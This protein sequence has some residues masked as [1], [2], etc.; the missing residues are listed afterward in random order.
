MLPTRLIAELF[1][2][3]KLCLICFCR[4][5]QR[6]TYHRWNL[7]ISSLPLLLFVCLIFICWSSCISSSCQD[8]LSHGGLS[9]LIWKRCLAQSPSLTYWCVWTLM[10]RTA[11]W[12]QCKC[13]ILHNREGDDQV[14]EQA[15]KGV[16][17]HGDNELN[18][19]F[20]NYLDWSSFKESYSE[21]YGSVQHRELMFSYF[22]FWILVFQE[23]NCCRKS[24]T[25]RERHDRRMRGCMKSKCL[26]WFW[27]NFLACIW[28]SQEV[29]GK[30][31]MKLSI[32]LQHQIHWF[33]LTKFG[34]TLL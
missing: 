29:G 7:P 30:G 17:G 31:E 12:G 5:A 8:K 22:L 1:C 15:G 9:S 32:A 3:I 23:I 34:H 20:G 16:V 11:L 6:S 21:L 24:F 28:V 26:H 2:K 4:A 13:K 14:D 10:Q 25:R 19:W 33:V 18:N 27:N